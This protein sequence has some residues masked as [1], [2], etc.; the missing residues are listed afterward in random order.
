MKNLPEVPAE[1][2]LRVIGGRWKLHV[3]WHL[4]EHR[5]RLSELQRLIP[6]I[7]QKVLIQQLRE[8]EAHGVVSREV[9]AEVPP[10][11]EYEA[12]PLG[13]TLRPLLESLCSWG[14]QH[15]QARGT[16]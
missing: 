13:L 10:R 6:G 5:R 16:R 7:T 2:A 1:R 14:R 15:A 9:F 12:T 4:L 3:L 11:V 8:L